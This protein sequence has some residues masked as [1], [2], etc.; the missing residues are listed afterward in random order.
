MAAKFRY[1]RPT[2]PMRG[3]RSGYRRTRIKVR[4]LA[5]L[6]PIGKRPAWP[7]R[8]LRPNRLARMTKIRA[9]PWPLRIRFRAPIPFGAS[10]ADRTTGFRPSWPSFPGSPVCTRDVKKQ[11]R[12]MPCNSLI[13]LFFPGTIRFRAPIPFGAS[14]AD[15]TTGFRPSWP[16]FPGSPVCTR[17]VKK[18]FRKMPCNSLIS[19]FFPGTI[20]GSENARCSMFGAVSARA[21]GV[22]AQPLDLSGY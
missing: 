17:D 12:K 2:G 16:S 6:A 10:A 14:A 7:P 11:F 4:L 3:V 15:R 21:D 1:C 20:Q 9:I 8:A 13:S 22:S 18:Q 19:L 5:V